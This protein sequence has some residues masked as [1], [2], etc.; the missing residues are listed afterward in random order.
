MAEKTAEQTRTFTRMVAAKRAWALNPDT[1]FYE[2]LVEGLT[3]NFNRYGYYLCP[4]RDSDGSRETDRDSI[5]PC[6]WSSGDVAEHGHCFCAL[7]LSPEFAASGKAPG[8]IRD[9]RYD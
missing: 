7:Y 8:A 5:C 2:T 6:L 4:C 9:R 3:A 1:P